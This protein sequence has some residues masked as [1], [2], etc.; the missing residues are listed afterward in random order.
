MGLGLYIC[1]V[2]CAK[3]GGSVSVSDAPEGGG[4]VVASFDVSS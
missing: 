2:L 1:S 4:I 3:H